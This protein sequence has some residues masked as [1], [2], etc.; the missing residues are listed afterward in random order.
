M[1]RQTSPWAE[2]GPPPRPIKRSTPAPRH[3]PEAHFLDSASL[4]DV[5]SSRKDGPTMTSRTPR[6]SWSS[7]RRWRLQVAAARPPPTGSSARWSRPSRN[8]RTVAATAN[9]RTVAHFGTKPAPAVRRSASIPPAGSARSHHSHA[10]ISSHEIEPADGCHT[11]QRRIPSTKPPNPHEESAAAAPARKSESGAFVTHN[12]VPRLA[13]LTADL[14]S[15][16]A[17]RKLLCLGL[18]DNGG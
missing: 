7:S 15:A 16:A 4:S 8:K 11:R 12:A 17:S 18:A 6:A 9:P 2:R 3:G 13:T 1:D 14:L 10:S 5:N